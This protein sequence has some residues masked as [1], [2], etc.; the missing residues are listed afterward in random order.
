MSM[1]VRMRMIFFFGVS[2]VVGDRIVGRSFAER[3]HGL[4]VGARGFHA[5]DPKPP[6]ASWLGPTSPPP[7]PEPD[8]VG[9]PSSGSVTM[10]MMTAH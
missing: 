1:K 3:W 6:G 4:W 2:D 9:P 8:G 5:V 7:H 10:M